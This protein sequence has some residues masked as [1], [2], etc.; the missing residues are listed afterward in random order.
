MILTLL[1][2]KTDKTDKKRKPWFGECP[3]EAFF[4]HKNNSRFARLSV[5]WVLFSFKLLIGFFV[6][7]K[8][9]YEIFCSLQKQLQSFVGCIRKS[10]ISF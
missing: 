8:F 1:T 9:L 7:G 10:N 3:A 5:F 2:E 6:S 4:A